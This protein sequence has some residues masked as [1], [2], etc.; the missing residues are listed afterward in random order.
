M[1]SFNSS[2]NESIV[3]NYSLRDGSQEKHNLPWYVPVFVNCAL[4]APLSITAVM[5]NAIVIYSIWNSPSLHSPSNTLLFSLAICDLS[6]GMIVQPFYIIYRM[7]YIT[8]Q[9]QTGVIMMKAFNVIS[10]LLCGVSFLTTTA[11]SIDRYLAVHLHLRYQELVT[12][13]RTGRLLVI[14][15]FV[16][17][18]VS[19]TLFWNLD[20]TFFGALL[21]I[22]SCLATTIGVY[23]RIFMVVRSQQKKIVQQ[24]AGQ[25]TTKAMQHTRSA[26]NM[27]YVCFVH[28]L[29]YLPYFVFLILRDG[30]ATTEFTYLATEFS[31]T[32]IFL[33]S[34]LNP[35]LYCWRLRDIRAAVKI[36]LNKFCCKRTVRICR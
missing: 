33:N 17:A 1:I 9:P 6:V 20:V 8:N 3:S 21:V 22:A 14:L 16:A 15:W 32:L 26:L 28:I 31:Q 4:N 36:T 35:V 18:L 11:V 23:A 12:V 27:F 2:F 24:R 7:F 10:N 30:Y 25:T 13:R 34:S 5:G 19:S 29:C